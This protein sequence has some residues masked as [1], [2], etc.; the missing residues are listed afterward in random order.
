AQGMLTYATENR[1]AILGSPV[2]TTRGLWQDRGA[3]GYTLASGVNI[4]NVPGPIE[5]FDFIYPLCRVM[6]IDVVQTSK[7]E[8][9]FYYYRTLRQFQCPAAQGTEATAAGYTSGQMLSYV[10]AATFLFTPPR[11]DN[12]NYN[13]RVAMSDGNYWTIPPEYAPRIDKVGDGSRKVY[14][15]DGARFTRYDSAP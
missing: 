12:I 3:T 1:G 8:T 9:K 4:N 13:G 10:T 11:T 15:A 2:N 7:A 5:L 14:A 6:R